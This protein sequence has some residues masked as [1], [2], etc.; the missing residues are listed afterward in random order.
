MSMKICQ[1]LLFVCWL[2]TALLWL[3]GCSALPGYV[4]VTVPPLADAEAERVGR[5]VET[6]LLQM[7]GGPYHDR[8]VTKSLDTL[9]A[10]PRA[11]RV[12][13]ADQNLPALYPLPGRRAI[14]TRGLLSAL[15][16]RTQLQALLSHAAELS[17]LVYAARATP[18]MLASVKVF[19]STAEDVYDPDAAVLRLARH[20]KA[21]AC[22]D[23]C[24]ADILSVSDRGSEAG[25][26]TLPDSIS[27][28]AKLQPAYDLL[29]SAGRF[30]KAGDQIRAIGLYL[31]A[32]VMAPEHPGILGPLG[33]AYLRSGQLQEARIHL[34]K[35]VKLQPGYYKTRMGLGYLYLQQGNLPL[36]N[37]FLASSVE[38]LA[39]EENLFLLAEAREKSSDPA[40]AISLYRLVVATASHSKLAEAASVR[41]QK[42]TG[43]K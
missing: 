11:F 2:L 12:V 1:K 8:G 21:E 23:A 28:L 19:L 9:A 6:K 16:R 26:A 30:E 43:T 34:Q 7:I 37:E 18:E 31:E 36:A 41:L 24:L 10:G 22:T 14:L 13:V 40:G 27:R 33:L 3:G 15:S 20:F 42:L 17:D 35:A 29:A 5:A 4:P 32:A 38:I 39:V 25:S